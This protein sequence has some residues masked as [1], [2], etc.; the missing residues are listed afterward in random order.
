MSQELERWKA[1]ERIRSNGGWIAMLLGLYGMLASADGLYG[2]LGSW[3][4]VKPSSAFIL[5]V[6]I[7]LIIC[8]VGLWNAKAWAR[9][10]I[11]AI[12][13]LVFT[14]AVSLLVSFRTF[15]LQLPVS[16]VALVYLLLPSTGRTFTRARTGERAEP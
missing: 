11:A 10:A 14:S 3:S 4:G 1:R 16:I 5:P 12:F 8:A 13:A 7:T 2:L 15:G 6:G 9:W